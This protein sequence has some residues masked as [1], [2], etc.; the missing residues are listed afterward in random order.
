MV[1]ALLAVASEP[2]EQFSLVSQVLKAALGL[3]IAYIAYR[4]YRSN[5]SRPMLFLA[6]GFVLV[7]GLPFAILLLSLFVPGIS[8]LTLVAVTEASLILGLLVILSALR[9]DP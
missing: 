3:T 7:L 6:L 2:I 8:E 1:D 4:G 9:M 5:R